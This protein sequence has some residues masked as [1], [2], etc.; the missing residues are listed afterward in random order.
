VADLKD[1]IA[2]DEKIGLKDSI[3]NLEI[4]LKNNISLSDLS[5]KQQ[6]NLRGETSS[7]T[8]TTLR[9][10]DTIVSFNVTETVTT[11]AAPFTS[12][13]GSS[14][15]SSQQKK[16]RSVTTIAASFTTSTTTRLLSNESQSSTQTAPGTLE[17]GG[18]VPGQSSTENSSQDWQPRTASLEPNRSP[19][20]T[21][22]SMSPIGQLTTE[23][24]VLPNSR[25]MVLI[26]STNGS[27]SALATGGGGA[28]SPRTGLLQD[29]S[30]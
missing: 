17:S 18:S 15:S 14:N 1:E 26:S 22:Q 24:F 28:S 12:S 10:R 30:T 2:R 9:K 21:S 5:N 25:S 8:T 11:T 7:S 19:I 20:K 27:V 6:Q 23:V 4:L 13:S 3:E 29:V 16:R